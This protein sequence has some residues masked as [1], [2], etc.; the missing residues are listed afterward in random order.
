ML[1]RYIKNDVN[2]NFFREFSEWVNFSG[3]QLKAVKNYQKF[4]NKYNSK[5]SKEN[6]LIRNG[7]TL[8]LKEEELP[9]T[10]EVGEKIEVDGVEYEV[11]STSINHG[12]LVLD[13]ERIYD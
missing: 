7:M 6:G 3:I 9:L 13:L 11:R 12:L 10:V 1:K 4:D 5:N 8:S 2:R